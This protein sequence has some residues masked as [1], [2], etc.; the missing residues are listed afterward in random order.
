MTTWP[1]CGTH[2]G[3]GR[4]R[5]AGSSTGVRCQGAP[6]TGAGCL[7]NVPGHL[8]S[9]PGLCLLVWSVCAPC[10]ETRTKRA[11]GIRPGDGGNE[12][13]WLCAPLGGG[14]SWVCCHSALLSQVGDFASYL[15][16]TCEQISPLRTHQSSTAEVNYIKMSK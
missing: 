4:G 2:C 7:S 5:E 11:F 10:A 3:N 8:G 13:S 16:T 14:S 1:C 6:G 15:L 9:W 12:D